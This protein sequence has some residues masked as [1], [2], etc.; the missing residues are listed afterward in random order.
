VANGRGVVKM[1][2]RRGLAYRQTPGDLMPTRVIKAA[3]FRPALGTSP[4]TLTCMTMTRATA[5]I[6]RR[7]NPPARTGFSLTLSTACAVAGKVRVGRNGRRGEGG[8]VEASW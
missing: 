7:S 4:I 8:V 3:T 5:P 1:A 2:P 6:A